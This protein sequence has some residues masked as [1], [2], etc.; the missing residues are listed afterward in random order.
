MRIG[1]NH[2]PH[3]YSMN[4]GTNTVPLQQT[5]CEKDLGVYTD[6]QL[7]FQQHI[8][9][10]TKKANQMVGLIRRSFHFLD[11]KMFS[12]LFKSM[13]RPILEYSNSVWSPHFK[14]DIIEIEK[15]QRRATKMVPGLTQLSYDERLKKLNIPSLEYRRT[16]GAMIDVYKC[17]HNMY[18]INFIWL[19][20]VDNSVTRGNSLKLV[21]QR[22][23]SNFKRNAFSQKIVNNWNS[24]SESTAN[25][26][27]INAF[28]SRIDREWSDRLYR[29]T[30]Y[31]MS[32]VE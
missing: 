6:D 1:K 31:G 9:M 22:N 10:K 28:K 16:R 5:N 25:A 24:L 7:T 14:K 15:V 3:E 4:K 20:K 13:V 11:E 30:E 12:L 23:E 26:P 18:D 21:K 2:Y 32:S 27:S 17:M 29:F 8:A 19:K